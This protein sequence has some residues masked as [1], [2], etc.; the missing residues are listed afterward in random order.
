MSMPRPELQPTQEQRM[1]VKQYAALGVPQEHI[2]RKVGIR[3]PKTLRLHYREELD[4]GQVEAN[5]TIAGALYKKAKDGH[6]D[7]QKFWL[8]NRAGWKDGSGTAQ[9]APSIPPFIV[10]GPEEPK[11]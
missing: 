2:A 6:V 11:S 7:A 5:A 8:K 1:M 9:S 10:T 3:S 4:L